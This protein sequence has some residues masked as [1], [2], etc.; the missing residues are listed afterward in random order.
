MLYFCLAVN[1]EFVLGCPL[2]VGHLSACRKPLRFLQTEA[3]SSRAGRVFH[4]LALRASL[5]CTPD[6]LTNSKGTFCTPGAKKKGSGGKRRPSLVD[7]LLNSAVLLRHSS[8]P[9]CAVRRRVSMIESRRRPQPPPPPTRRA[10]ARGRESSAGPVGGR[11]PRCGPTPTSVPTPVRNDANKR[12]AV[13][14]ISSVR[15]RFYCCSSAGRE[16]KGRRGAEGVLPSSSWLV[17][18]LV[19][20]AYYLCSWRFD[21]PSTHGEASVRRVPATFFSFLG[22]GSGG[23]VDVHTEGT[24]RARERGEKRDE[25]LFSGPPVLL[26]CR[27]CYCC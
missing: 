15:S 7:I 18:M 5:T 8:F 12:A 19:H 17:L 1:F 3:E 24:G 4:S 9:C 11:G 26:C 16:G 10:K 13:L 6:R 25:R 27:C 21:P 14:C 23:W 20:G 2:W 22:G